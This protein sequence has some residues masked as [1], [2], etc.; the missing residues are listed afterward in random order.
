MKKSIPQ[1]K[2]QGFPLVP[3]DVVKNQLDKSFSFSLG[4]VHVLAA[5][6][7]SGKSTYLRKYAQEYINRGGQSLAI[8]D[9]NHINVKINTVDGE[10]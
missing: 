4:G 5:P 3:N 2:L 6:S 10:C 9:E 8:C 1:Y 7:G